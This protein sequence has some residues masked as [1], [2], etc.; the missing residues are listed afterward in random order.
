MAQISA[1]LRNTEH[2]FCH[3]CPG[4]GEPHHI[5]VSA[6]H[7]NAPR[8][9]FDGRVHCP[10]FSPSVRITWRDPD[11]ELPDEICHYFIT[12][13]QIQFCADSTHALAGQTVP[14]PPLPTAYQDR[15]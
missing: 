8:W 7:P 6:G 2:G 13:G 1:Y 14:L 10:T 9:E 5:Y 4:C 11:G 15:C 3:W 12:A